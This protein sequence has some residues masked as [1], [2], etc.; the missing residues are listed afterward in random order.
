MDE[1]EFPEEIGVVLEK[2]EEMI[3][4]DLYEVC[5]SMDRQEES[6]ILHRTY[7]RLA[8]WIKNLSP[9]LDVNSCQTIEALY[10]VADTAIE[11][12]F[13][14]VCLS[15]SQLFEN[16]GDYVPRKDLFPNGYED[17]KKLVVYYHQKGLKNHALCFNNYCLA[18]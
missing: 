14:L 2:D 9:E 3:S 10:E 4:F 15:V 16:I 17:V 1:G 8:P 13:E 18:K 7:K 5:T 12:G 11:S 6:V